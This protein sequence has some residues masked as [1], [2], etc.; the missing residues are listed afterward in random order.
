MVRYKR[1][2]RRPTNLDRRRTSQPLTATLRRAATSSPLSP[3]FSLVN[4][5]FSF[6]EVTTSA[7]NIKLAYF[8]IY[9]NSDQFTFLI[10][11]ISLNG[12][13][14]NCRSN[15]RA[16]SLVLMIMCPLPFNV[17]IY[18]TCVLL[19]SSDQNEACP[20]LSASRLLERRRI[21]HLN[22]VS[23]VKQHHKVSSCSAIASSAFF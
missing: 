21:F 12:I 13:Y 19:S 7:Q 17:F 5:P 22:L 16:L 9:Y 4:T 10:N 18:L 15:C 20:L 8:N 6:Y 23:I 2:F 11:T 14:V 3:S 1:C